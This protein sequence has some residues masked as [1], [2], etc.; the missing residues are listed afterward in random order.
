MPPIGEVA[1][2]RFEEFCSTTSGV[3]TLSRSRLFALPAFASVLAAALIASSAVPAFAASPAGEVIVT[4]IAP[5]NTGVDSFEYVEVVNTASTDV[6]VGARSRP[7]PK[8]E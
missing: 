4:E 7:R 5:D 2:R 8:V 3:S 6:T 1:A